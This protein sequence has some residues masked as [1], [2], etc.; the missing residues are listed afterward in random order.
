MDFLHESSACGIPCVIF[1]NTGTS[2]LIIHK[3]GYVAKNQD[4][5]DLANGIRWCL[6]DEN[7]KKICKEIKSKN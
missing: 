5:N 3:N 1:E 6:E 7:Y 2:D 4:V